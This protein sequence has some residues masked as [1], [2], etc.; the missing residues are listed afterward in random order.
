VNPEAGFFGVAPGT[1]R[2]S[3]PNAMDAV[4]KNTIFTNV[5]LIPR[6]RSGG[7]YGRRSAG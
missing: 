1:S 5:V 4:K 3:N 2:K 6:A 7:G